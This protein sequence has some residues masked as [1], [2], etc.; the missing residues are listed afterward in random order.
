MIGRF[1]EIL[2][3]LSKSLHLKL[4]VDKHGACA[5]QIPP[6][7]IQ[8]QPNL[9]QESLFLFVKLTEVPP[10][11]FRENVFREALKANGRKDPRAGILGYMGPL[12]TLTLHQIYPFSVLSGGR[13]ANFLAGFVE[14]AVD[15]KGAIESGHSAPVGLKP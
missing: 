6:L 7:V 14:A 12:N 11:K 10:G 5:I 1:E 9:T 15:W 4:H 8:L 3:E 13:L 2:E